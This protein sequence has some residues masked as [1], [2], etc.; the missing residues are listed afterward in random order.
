MNPA[1]TRSIMNFAIQ[2]WPLI[3][4][5]FAAGIVDSMGGG[6]GLITV[7]TLL[8]IGV[9]PIFLLGTNKTI[10][11]FGS[12]PALLRYR[13]ANLLPQLAWQNWTFLVLICAVAA[14]L[15]AFLSQQ[16]AFLSHISS[17]IPFLLILVMGF[18]IKRWFWNPHAKTAATVGTGDLSRENSSRDLLTKLRQWG[19][20]AG[21]G[22]V[23]CYDGLLGPG[24]GA[25]YM[26]LLEYHG[27]QTLSANA[28]TKVFNLASN[29]GALLFFISLGR[30]L[31][32]FGIAGA[33]FYALGSYLGSGFVLKR[34]QNLVRVVVLIVTCCLLLRYIVRFLAEAS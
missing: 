1:L 28:T 12:L 9:P 4:A 17:I 34:G 31:W 25:F 32:S 19:T 33:L 20:S 11:T 8:N 16:E 30:N 15:G 24:A 10:T 23:A 29:I 6:G 3:V 27:V 2:V 13:R 14:A 5:A 22:G 26:N 18:M 21:I 7:P